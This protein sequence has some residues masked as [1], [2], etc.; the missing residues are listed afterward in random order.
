MDR[1]MWTRRLATE[2]RLRGYDQGYKFLYCPWSTLGASGDAFIS[3]NPGGKT[4]VGADLRTLSDERGNSY[5]VERATTES[6]I[7][8]QFLKFCDLVGTHYSKML[9]GVAMPYRTT[10]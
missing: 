10:S 6:P 1:E 3:L 2:E 8:E 9:T 5:Y 7:T 4:P